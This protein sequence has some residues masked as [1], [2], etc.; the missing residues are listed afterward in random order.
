MLTRAFHRAPRWLTIAVFGAMSLA[1]LAPMSFPTGPRTERAKPQLRVSPTSAPAGATIA[2]TITGRQWAPNSA[3]AIDVR[4]GG[5]LVAQR[6]VNANDEGQFTGAVSFSVPN[7][8]GVA[9]IVEATSAQASDSTATQTLNIADPTPPPSPTD[10]ALTPSPAD[11]TPTPSPT[12]PPPTPTDPPPTPSPTDPPSTPT[13]PPPTQTPLPPT[14]TPPPPT[15][16]PPP[17]PPTPT[18]PSAPPPTSPPPSPTPRPPATQPPA[19]QPPATQPPATRQPATTPPTVSPGCA[20]SRDRALAGTY[21]LATC[22]RFTIGHSVRAVWPNGQALT[23]V[24]FSADPQAFGFR[25]PPDARPGA[26]TVRFVDTIDSSIQAAA[27][28]TITPTSSGT[29]P[30]PPI[31]P[32]I[33]GAPSGAKHNVVV[34]LGGV[35]TGLGFGANPVVGRQTGESQQVDFTDSNQATF[36][37]LQQTLRQRYGYSDSDFL[38]Y[39]YNGGFVDGGGVWRH[40]PYLPTDLMRNDLDQSVQNLHSLLDEYSRAHPDTTFILVGHSLGGVVA[41]QELN[42]VASADYAKGSISISTIITVDSPLAGVTRDTFNA[43]R[44]LNL[45]LPNKV[46]DCTAE[47]FYDMQAT[48][49]GQRLLDMN[50]SRSD[51]TQTNEQLVAAAQRQG[52]RVV[53]FG[54]TWDC[55][56]APGVCTYPLPLAQGDIDTQWIPNSAA[57]TRTIVDSAGCITV[58][59]AITTAC[60]SKTHSAA[61][62]GESDPEAESAVANAI[63]PRSPPQSP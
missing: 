45:A 39:S 7:T 47:A 15:P 56:Y 43:S 18:P 17:P 12:D 54:N 38:A 1:L 6:T 4:S 23:T 20:L 55:L 14:P 60:A 22:S 44:S 24:S 19:T 31:Q 51:T 21:V 29:Q 49:T 52:V 30:T 25:I 3:V 13:T 8:P 35:C 42:Y 26:Y 32:P 5:A 58:F 48:A 61:L 59:H 34:F 9:L 41:F 28:I 50:G 46:D 57:E 62:N 36:H 40:R 63:G 27:P 33:P 2:R 37:Y 53:N 10:P 11:P 16:T